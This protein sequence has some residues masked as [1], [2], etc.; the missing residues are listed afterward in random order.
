MATSETSK[1]RHLTAP[2]C[3]GAGVD[4]GSAGDPVVPHAIQIDLQ[5]PYCPLIGPG[6]I[7]LRGDGRKLWW[8]RRNCLTFVYSSHLIEDFDIGEWPE[9][10]KE[11]DSVL[12]FG[13]HL[14]IL[15][16]EKHRWA[17]AITGGQPPNLAHKHEP[18][19]GEISREV[20]NLMDYEI[21]LDTCPDPTD[22]GIVFIAK[23]I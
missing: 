7:H 21:I 18:E 14:I 3:T 13:G 6:P 19:V 22:Y 4:I 15:A 23:K 2:Y 16:P 20:L 11:W 8:F 10:L 9:L 1:Y 17:K 12:Q 5:K